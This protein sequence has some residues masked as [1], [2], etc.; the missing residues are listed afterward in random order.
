MR[1]RAVL[2]STELGMTS[3]A[4]PRMRTVV[5]R[6]VTSVTSPVTSPTEM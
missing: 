5:L 4:P 2:E 6:Q 1:V 3:W